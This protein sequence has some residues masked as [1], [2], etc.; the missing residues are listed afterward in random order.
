MVQTAMQ[1]DSGRRRAWGKADHKAAYKQLPLGQESRDFAWIAIQDPVSGKYSLHQAKTLI[2]G[3]T[4]AV[5][6]YNCVSRILA[7]LACRCLGIP[8]VGYFDDF[9]F[10]IPEE[11][12]PDALHTFHEFNRI[13]GFLM[14]E[15]KSEVGN[16]VEFLGLMAGFPAP[17]IRDLL[18]LSITKEKSKKWRALIRDLLDLGIIKHGQLDK[19]VGILAFARTMVFARFA[20]SISTPIYEMLYATPY[21]ERINDRVRAALEWWYYFL[22][23]A[24]PRAI[25]T[26]A[27]PPVLTAYSDASFKTSASWGGLGAVIFE[28]EQWLLSSR[29]SFTL[30]GV[31]C[32]TILEWAREKVE[33]NMIFF[34]ELIAALGAIIFIASRFENVTIRFFIDNDAATGTLTRAGSGKDMISW[35]TEAFWYVAASK[36]LD[37]WLERVPSKSNIADFPSREMPLPIETDHTLPF[38]SAESM[39]AAYP[40]RFPKNIS[41]S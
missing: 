37:I 5:L 41:E 3:S 24:P 1:L 33:T 17:L 16:V 10:L 34:L 28:S 9:G 40:F 20:R 38:P 21:L 25:A 31:A 2:F 29:A 30:Q 22:E 14:K 36:N 27:R 8:C 11:L 6:H 35:I 26:Q 23:I 12:G 13:L 7:S 39:Q 19:L 18:E 32:H 15:S 4:V